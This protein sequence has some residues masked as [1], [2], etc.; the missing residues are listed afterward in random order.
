MFMSSLIIHE[1]SVC[2][3]LQVLVKIFF[4]DKHDKVNNKGNKDDK[5]DGLVH[6]A[7]VVRYLL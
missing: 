3:N 7:K 4:S 5:D 1:Q 6:S 2:R